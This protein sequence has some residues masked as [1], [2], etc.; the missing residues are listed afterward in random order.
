MSTGYYVSHMN[1]KN[2]CDYAKDCYHYISL[3]WISYA[4]FHCFL[5][6]L[7][8]TYL[9]GGQWQTKFFDRGTAPMPSRFAAD[10]I[11]CIRNKPWPNPEFLSY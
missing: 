9:V 2:N 7:K 5:F 6:R 1:E 3:Y 4:N 10:N 11:F 8:S